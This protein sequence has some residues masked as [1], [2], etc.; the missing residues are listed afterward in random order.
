MIKIFAD[1]QTFNL[2]FFPLLTVQGDQIGRWVIGSFL[3]HISK[4]AFWAIFS[5]G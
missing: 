5:Y 3:L 4:V 2:N 1:F